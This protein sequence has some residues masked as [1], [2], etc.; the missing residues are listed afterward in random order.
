[1]KEEIKERLINYLKFLEDEWKDYHEYE[2]FTW[3]IYYKNR[4]KRREIERWIENVLNSVIDISKVIIISE[5]YKLPETYKEMVRFL[6]LFKH[7]EKRCMDGLSSYV[8]LRNIITHEYIDIKWNSIENFLKDSKSLIPI[9]IKSVQKYL[10]D[11][12][13]KGN[14]DSVKK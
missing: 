2:N 11:K 1:M 10:K 4:K 7:F 13:K 12:L 3:D 9:F 14:G 5:E 6:S 8:N